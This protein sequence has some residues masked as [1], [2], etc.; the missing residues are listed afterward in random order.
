MA[1][2]NEIYKEILNIFP[3]LGW[4]MLFRIKD[5]LPAI[6]YARRNKSTGKV[7]QAILTET[8]DKNETMLQTLG[9]A[10]RG[11]FNKKQCDTIIESLRNDLTLSKIK[12]VVNNA[13]NVANTKKAKVNTVI[14]A[15]ASKSRV[16]KLD[17]SI[18]NGDKNPTV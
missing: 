7:E 11:V 18:N 13:I 10:L 8:T 12:I 6:L 17:E 4:R 16:S 15:A 2:K 9:V 1:Q 5:E 3:Q 14:K